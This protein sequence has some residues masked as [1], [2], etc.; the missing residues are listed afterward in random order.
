MAK[1]LV[2]EDD[3]TLAEVT[4]FGL[5]SQGHIVQV[6]PNGD[7]ALV[8]LRVNKYDLIVLDWMMPDLTGIEVLETYRKS[9]GKT[10]VLML[11]AKARLEDKE[12]GLDAGADD[13]LTKPFEHREL[14]ARIRALLRRPTSLASIVLEVTDITLDPA[15]CVV[16]RA[17]HEV[18]LRPKVYSLLEFLMRHP[19]QVFSAEAILER[20]WL[21]DAMVSTDTVRAHFKLLRKSLNLKEESIIRTVRNRGY[22]LVSDE[23]R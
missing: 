23:A 14:Q 5:E 8:N 10:P 19:N 2:V 13:Y 4:K 12:Q 9:G 21:D 15:T 3:T 20:V 7:D 18:K 17:G 16:T 11:T 6:C 1:I 22:M